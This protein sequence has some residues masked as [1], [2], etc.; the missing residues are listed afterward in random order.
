MLSEVP[1]TGITDWVAAREIRRCSG[2]GRV[3]AQPKRGKS[4]REMRERNGVLIKW[5]PNQPKAGRNKGKS[6]WVPHE[7]SPRLK[8]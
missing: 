8:I 5:E 2:G 1:F 3:A 4:E 6:G 7:S